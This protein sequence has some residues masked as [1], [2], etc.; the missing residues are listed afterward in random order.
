MSTIFRQQNECQ[1]ILKV[2]LQAFKRDLMTRPTNFQKINL[3]LI[4]LFM[5]FRDIYFLALVVS[6]WIFS[7]LRVKI[8][9]TKWPLL[10][11]LSDFGFF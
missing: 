7:C 2:Q 10:E 11:F 4:L 6:F 5:M 3:K 9:L 1:E 8:S